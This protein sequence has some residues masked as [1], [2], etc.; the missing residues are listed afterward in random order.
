MTSDEKTFTSLSWMLTSD[1][2]VLKAIL[3]KG[4]RHDVIRWA[5]PTLHLD[6]L[7]RRKFLVSVLICAGLCPVS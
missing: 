6:A 2:A 5:L 1:E 7:K 3:K 4:E